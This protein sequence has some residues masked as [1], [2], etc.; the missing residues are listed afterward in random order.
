MYNLFHN[1]KENAKVLLAIPA[2]SE[3]SGVNCMN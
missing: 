1:L 3:T 2:V